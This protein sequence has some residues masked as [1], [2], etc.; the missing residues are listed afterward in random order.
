MCTFLRRGV[1]CVCRESSIMRSLTAGTLSDHL[2]AHASVDG[3]KSGT[4]A[5]DNTYLI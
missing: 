1:W 3:S 4:R 2:N 5:S